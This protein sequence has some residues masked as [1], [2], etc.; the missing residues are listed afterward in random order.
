MALR[1]KSDWIL[2]TTFIFMVFY[3]ALM[4]YS[5]SS[6]KAEQKFGS[7]YHFIGRQMFWVVIGLIVMMALKRFSYRKLAHPGVAFAGMAFALILLI[8]VYFADPSQHRW[9]R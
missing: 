2:F 4:V 5:A 7:S 8:I 1:L 3:G 6:V 9:I